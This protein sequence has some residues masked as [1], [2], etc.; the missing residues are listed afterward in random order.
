MTTFEPL[1]LSLVDRL[2][3]ALNDAIELAEQYGRPVTAKNLRN[4]REELEDRQ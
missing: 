4:L 1:S 3:D 2:I